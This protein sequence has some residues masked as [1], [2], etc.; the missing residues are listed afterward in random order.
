M[1]ILLCTN[2][3][4]EAQV[5]ARYGVKLAK[6]LEAEVTVLGIMERADLVMRLDKAVKEVRS[7]LTEEGVPF[8]ALTRRGRARAELTRQTREKR[9]D[10][11][12]VGSLGR[13][14]WSRFL[15]GPTWGRILRAVETSVLIVRV[16]KPFSLEK[17][18]VC[19]GG[20]SHADQVARFGGK[21]LQMVGASATLLHVVDPL[22]MEHLT[23]NKWISL[24]QFVQLDIPQS[25]HFLIGDDMLRGLG[26]EVEMK[27]RHGFATVE[28]LQEA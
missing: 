18:L 17:A 23:F 3:S 28:I 27:L 22:L 10:L 16:E 12:V 15:R 14:W 26:I 7:L 6:I 1:R 19:S 8:Q 9:Y 2:G 13:A 21:I 24:E 11:V 25:R 5:A 4:E 20:L